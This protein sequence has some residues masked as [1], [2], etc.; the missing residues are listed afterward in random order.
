MLSSKKI[1]NRD[2]NGNVIEDLSK[3]K[4]PQELEI[5]IFKILNPEL[6]IQEVK[7]VS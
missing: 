7:F 2:K 4:L 1:I 3:V 6:R 5:S